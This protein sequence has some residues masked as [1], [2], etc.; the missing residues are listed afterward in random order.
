MPLA[1]GFYRRLPKRQCTGD[2]L[3]MDNVTLYP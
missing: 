3:P 2:Y 1:R